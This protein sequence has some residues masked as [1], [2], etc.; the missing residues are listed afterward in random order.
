MKKIKC[1]DP[2]IQKMVDEALAA[3]EYV[4]PGVALI[5]IPKEKG[6]IP[7]EVLVMAKKINKRFKK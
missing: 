6:P 4:P 7:K 5:E 3:G 2:N 1:K